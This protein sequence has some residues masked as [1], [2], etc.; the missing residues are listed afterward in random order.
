M[1]YVFIDRGIYICSN[2]CICRFICIEKVEYVYVYMYKYRNLLNF[3][4][5]D[6]ERNKEKRLL[7]FIKVFMYVICIYIH[8]FMY[9]YIHKYKITW[10][11]NFGCREKYGKT[12]IGVCRDMII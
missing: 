3:E 1:W 6:I 2:T 5:L 7:G 11:I 9:M 12:T 4:W 8:M 10:I